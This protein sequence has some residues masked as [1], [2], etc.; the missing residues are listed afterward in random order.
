M[1][2]VLVFWTRFGKSLFRI[3]FRNSAIAML[4]VTGFW[5]AAF[6]EPLYVSDVMYIFLRNGPGDQHNTVGTVKSDEPLE[7]IGESGDYLQV[8]TQTGEVGYIKKRYATSNTPDAIIIERLKKEIERLGAGSELTNPEPGP[9]LDELNELK[10]TNRILTEKTGEL[11]NDKISSGEEITRL[12]NELKQAGE[13]Y[14]TLL[15]KS[16]SDESS[17]LKKENEKIKLEIE[18]LK[19]K[20]ATNKRNSAIDNFLS[21]GKGWMLAG[22]LVCLLGWFLGRLS[23]PSRKRNIF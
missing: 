1:K 3:R 19:E 14:Q 11:E 15:A 22:G 7:L 18:R 9:S 23:R 16:K 6:C 12:S 2:K 13:S 20:N 4:F 8:R 10:E 21:S 5:G 17:G